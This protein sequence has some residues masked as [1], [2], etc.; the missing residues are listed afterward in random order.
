MSLSAEFVLL[1]R[2]WRKLDAPVHTYKAGQRSGGTY[3]VEANLDHVRTSVI[4]L[5]EA[6]MKRKDW[7]FAKR[8]NE[9]LS[10]LQTLRFLIEQHAPKFAQQY[11]SY[12]E[13]TEQL[14]R[15]MIVEAAE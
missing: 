1:W 2:R 13:V 7:D 5:G 3:E 8:A 14:L 11:L 12:V 6:L 10:E 15:K 9:E 4:S